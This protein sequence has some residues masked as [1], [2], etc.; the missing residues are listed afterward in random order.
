[1]LITFSV[2]T[3]KETLKTGAQKHL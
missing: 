2:V 1:M 3:D